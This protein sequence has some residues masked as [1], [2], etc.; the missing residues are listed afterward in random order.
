M[1]LRAN[2][3]PVSSLEACT[4][5]LPYANAQTIY[6]GT[7]SGGW[8]DGCEQLLQPTLLVMSILWPS[9]KTFAHLHAICFTLWDRERRGTTQ[10]LESDRLSASHAARCVACHG[11]RSHPVPVALVGECSMPVV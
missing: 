3:N 2:S 8:C 10:S 11:V 5:R 9:E 6:G 7:G 1:A 4:G